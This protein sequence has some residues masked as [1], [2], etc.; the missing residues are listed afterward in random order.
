MVLVSHD[1]EFIF[2]KTRKTAGTSIEMHL[3]KYCAAPGFVSTETTPCI[4]SDYGIVGTLRKG[5]H[6]PVPP[7]LQKGFEMRS[8]RIWTPH[9]P[10]RRLRRQLGRKVFDRYTKLSAVRNPFERSVSLYLFRLWNKKIPVPEDFR[11]LVKDFEKFVTSFRFDNDK[12]VTHFGGR[13]V[14]DHFI[15]YE[16]LIDD[17]ENAMNF[18]G[19]PPDKSSLAVTKSLRHKRGQRSIAE[20]YTDRSANAVRKRMRWVFDKFDYSPDPRDSETIKSNLD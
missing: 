2:L 9:M 17:L 8:S 5:K 7:E 16:S 11:D 18:L 4:I 14:V 15:R 13:M 10:V 1:R 3:Q 19:L 12:K 20:F 6:E